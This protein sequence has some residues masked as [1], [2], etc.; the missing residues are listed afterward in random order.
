VQS[1]IGVELFLWSLLLLRSWLFQMERDALASQYRTYAA[2]VAPVGLF[3]LCGAVHGAPIPHATLY[4]SRPTDEELSLTWRA[5]G[6]L[7]LALAF[8]AFVKLASPALLEPF[9]ALRRA[10]TRGAVAAHLATQ[11]QARLWVALVLYWPLKYVAIAARLFLLVANLRLLGFDVASGFRRPF[12]A[13]NFVDLWRRWNHYVRDAAMVLFFFPALGALRRKLSPSLAQAGAVL[14]SFAALIV[15]ET[16]LWPAFQLPIVLDRGSL[17]VQ[18]GRLALIGIITAVTAWYAVRS[19]R[20]A[21]VAP[22]WARPLATL[23]TIISAA[24]ISTTAAVLSVFPSVR[25]LVDLGR[26]LFGIV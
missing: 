13:R 5:V 21:S 24:A 26:Y 23:T 16:C 8:Q 12:L 14:A 6:L 7:A 9:Y 20:R 11:D 15:V 17:N 18:R 19:Q 22:A 25:E 1:G 3:A 4:G 2:F 10:A